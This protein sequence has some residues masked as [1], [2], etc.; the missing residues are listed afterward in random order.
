MSL[1]ESAQ[2]LTNTDF[3][4]R[5]QIAMLRE[6]YCIAT[7]A[8]S[9]DVHVDLRRHEAMHNVMFNKD[10]ARDFILENMISFCV[11]HPTIIQII[12]NNPGATNHNDLIP[13]ATIISVI[14]EL[15][16]IMSGVNINNPQL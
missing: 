6:A 15:T 13:D 2:L 5:V 8:S 1:S 9:G 14:T 3:R 10:D 4:N 7:E 12:D 16:N 11:G